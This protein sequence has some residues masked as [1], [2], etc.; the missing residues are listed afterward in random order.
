MLVRNS[1]QVI[2]KSPEK[3]NNVIPSLAKKFKSD[4]TISRLLSHY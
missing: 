3:V 4:D 2:P 1:G